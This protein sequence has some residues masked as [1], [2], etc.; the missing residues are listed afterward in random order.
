MAQNK[1]NIHNKVRP[2]AMDIAVF[3]AESVDFTVLPPPWTFEVFLLCLSFS[4]TSDFGSCS[5]SVLVLQI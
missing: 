1:K 5:V 3:G 4:V 2:Q